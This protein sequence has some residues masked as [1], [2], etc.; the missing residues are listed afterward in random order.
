[1]AKIMLTCLA[2]GCGKDFDAE[3]VNCPACVRTLTPE[4][5]R[6]KEAHTV[7]ALTSAMIAAGAPD[8]EDEPMT[9]SVLTEKDSKGRQR[10]ETVDN[11]DAHYAAHGARRVMEEGFYQGAKGT[12]KLHRGAHQDEKAAHV[13]LGSDQ[14]I[15]ER[16]KAAV[17]AINARAK[18]DRAE[19]VKGI[20]EKLKANPSDAIP[21]V[22]THGADVIAEA[23]AL[24]GVTT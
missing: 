9:I 8:P 11:S 5:G 22:R 23:L 7:A 3:L 21:L 6:L 2:R 12:P 10:V 20:A 16:A 24:L 17:E 14:A 15:G 18:S 4:H 13:V 19:L 1:M